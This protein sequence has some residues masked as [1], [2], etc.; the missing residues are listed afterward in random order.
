[1]GEISIVSPKSVTLALRRGRFQKIKE[2]VR[3]LLSK[4]KMSRIPQMILVSMKA[5]VHRQ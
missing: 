2:T 5:A 4:I 3:L 1:M